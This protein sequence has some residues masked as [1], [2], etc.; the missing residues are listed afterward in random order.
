MRRV[1]ALLMYKIGAWQS[2]S[3][4][5]QTVGLD[6]GVGFTK[7]IQIDKARE[8]SNKNSCSGQIRCTITALIKQR[9]TIA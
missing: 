7:T 5:F 2:I 3:F 9:V 8:T 6:I 1:W 4:V